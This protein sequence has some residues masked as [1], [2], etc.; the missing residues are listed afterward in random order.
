MKYTKCE[1]DNGKGDDKCGLKDCKTAR[2]AFDLI[3]HQ[4]AEIENLKVENQSLRGAANS[5]KMHYKEA[6]A[7]IERLQNILVAFM[8]AL[9]K[10]KN[11][12]DIES[13]TQIPI[14]W[15]LNK[16]FRAEIKSKAVKEFAEKVKEKAMQKFDWNEY[17]EV[18]EIN[19]LV[20]ELVGEDND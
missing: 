15:E 5:L 18:D 12:E 10:V 14:M 1:Y 16:Q 17:V 8:S 6:Q 20:K 13:I 4:K 19:N 7:E 9:G 3:T 11:V 2:Y